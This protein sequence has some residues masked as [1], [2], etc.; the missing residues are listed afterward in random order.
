MNAEAIVDEYVRLGFR[1]IFVR[2][3][4]RYGFAARKNILLS[5]TLVATSF[6]LTSF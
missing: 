6:S 4:S 5:Y 3:I 1:E 2:P